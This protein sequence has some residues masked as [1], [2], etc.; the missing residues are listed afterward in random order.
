MQ[1]DYGRINPA[2]AAQWGSMGACFGRLE[3]KNKRMVIMTMMT[4]NAASQYMQ[5]AQKL[6]PCALQGKEV[7]VRSCLEMIRVE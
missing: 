5:K 1:I 6:V 4:I 3:A 7:S 2:N